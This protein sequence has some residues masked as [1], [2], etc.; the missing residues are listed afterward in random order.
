MRQAII[1]RFW[2]YVQDGS[3]DE[4]WPWTGGTI[5]GYGKLNHDNTY[6]L[7]HRFAWELLIG[8][9][10]PGMHLDHRRCQTKRCVNPAHMKV[11]TLLENIEQPDGIV[12]IHRARTHCPRGHPYSG[13]NLLTYKGRH[14]RTCQRVKWLR[15]SKERSA[16]RKQR[17]RSNGNGIQ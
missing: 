16:N 5:K 12:A 11:G 2:R 13:D 6:T 1:D 14:C 10:P 8:P 4:C 7:T 9:I 15:Q 17:N 3:P